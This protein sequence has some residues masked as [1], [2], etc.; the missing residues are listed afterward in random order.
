MSEEPCLQRLSGNAI[1]P[2]LPDLARL[3]IQVFWEYPYLYQGTV[4]YE[5]NYLQRYADNPASVMVLVWIGDRVVGASSGLP[6]TAEPPQLIEPFLTHGY[7][8]ARLFYY[9]E[10]VLLPDY[11]NRGLGKRFFEEREAHV[12]YLARFDSVCFCAVERPA[13][14]PRRP[15]GYQPL[16]AFWHRRGFVQHPELRATFSWQDRDET[17]ESAKPMVFWLKPLG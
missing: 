17:A 8:P 1:N 3:R 5:E 14:H 6:L 11:R 2:Y 4:A 16:D 15:A 7:D 13:D 12:R 10:S 9:G